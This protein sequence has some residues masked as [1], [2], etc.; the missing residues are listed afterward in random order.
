MDLFRGN[1]YTD[2]QIPP[3][4]SSRSESQNDS[5]KSPARKK[6]D[7]KSSP[8]VD[9][10]MGVNRQI[11]ENM[12]M[13]NWLMYRYNGAPPYTPTLPPTGYPYIMPP[14]HMNLPQARV[15]HEE[16]GG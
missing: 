9:L 10:P 1:P 14:V 12:H 15:D 4:K 11:M 3:S 16:N 8:S 5:G 6:P 13:R 2:Q 7:N